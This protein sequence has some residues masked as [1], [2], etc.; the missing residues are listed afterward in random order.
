MRNADYKRIFAHLL[1]H[2][3]V[4]YLIL[5]E[6]SKRWMHYEYDAIGRAKK[7]TNPDNTY[8]ETLY[9]Q[10]RTTLIDAN[11]RQKVEEKDVYGRLIKV[12]EYTGAYP[13][14]SPY[15][16]TTYEYDV[17]GNLKKVTD[18]KGNQTII[19]YDSLSRKINMN[20][21][22]MGYWSYTYDLN[23][24]LETQTDAKNQTIT[25]HYDQLNRI[26][27]KDYLTGTDIVYTYD[28]T[29]STNY[30]G[31]LTTVTDSSGS[32]KFYYDKMGRTKTTIKTVDGINYQIDTTYDELGRTASII[33]P[34]NETVYYDYDNGGNLTSVSNYATFSK[35]NALGQSGA[36]TYANGVT[37]TQQYYTTNNRL[38]SITTNGPQGGLQ[39]LSYNYDNA[40]NI[41]TITDSLDGSRT[42]SFQYDHLN[43]L[44]QAYRPAYGTITYNYNEIGNIT[45][46]SRVGSYSYW[47]DY[48]GTKPHAV[49]YAGSYTYEYDVNGNMTMRNGVTIVYDY[50]NRPTNIGSLVLVYDY[51][52]Q[53]VK[54]NSMVYIG[55]I[56]EC[57]GSTCTKYILSASA[58]SPWRTGS[59]RIASQ[60]SSNTY[61]YH[62]DHLG[63]SSVITDE[64]GNKVQETYYYPFGETWY[65]SG[66]ATHYKFTGQEEDPETGLYYY[67][68]RYYDPVIGKFISAAS[69]VQ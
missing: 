33:Y 5:L 25:F 52:G 50:D 32:E 63:S 23:G 1:I 47:K 4:A 3:V 16:T 12:E 43:R 9:M 46:N 7:I 36:I 48:Y 65:N 30:K 60:A 38:Y 37:T 66:N 42:Q 44:T 21:P 31:R 10:G 59:A 14:A 8:V 58:D 28:E 68:A 35:F 13:T 56:Y 61:F 17:L 64:L 41:T 34:D 45:Y 53:R 39:N 54:K 20:D 15:A 19:N 57:N 69:I 2:R 55:K 49:R 67:G 22:D 6:L 24:N 51:S 18:A 11:R 62:T 26:T 40:G 29:W 27:W